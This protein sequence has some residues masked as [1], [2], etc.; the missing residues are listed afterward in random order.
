MHLRRRLGAVLLVLMVVLA[1]SGCNDDDGGNETGE[2]DDTEAT[3]P[4]ADGATTTAGEDDE[5]DGDF[6]GEDSEE[7]CEFAREMQDAEVFGGDTTDPEE[8]ESQIESLE[9]AIE[10]L[11]E[12]APDEIADDLAVSTA[13]IQPIIDLYRDNDYD[14]AAIQQAIAENPDLFASLDDPA[15]A[16]ANTNVDAYFADVCGITG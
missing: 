13:A 1:A 3:T 5:T 4:T 14:M 16:Q 15:I 6:T 10:R 2:R 12:L 9:V 7:L 11:N 8:L